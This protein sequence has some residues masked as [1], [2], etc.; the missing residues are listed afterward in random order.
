VSEHRREATAP[1]AR[2]G[3]VQIQAIERRQPPAD[4]GRRKMQCGDH[5]QAAADLLGSDLADEIEQRHQ[6]LVLVAMD[7]AREHQCGTGTVFHDHDRNRHDAPG[8]I[9]MGLR[10]AQVGRM[11]ALTLEVGI[12]DDA[13]S[14]LLRVHACI[15]TARGQ[16][17]RLASA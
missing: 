15:F 4:T 17:S 2:K 5:D 12:G 16:R 11:L 14:S 8:G 9:V 1:I 10:H 6:A 13:R 7:T 3:P